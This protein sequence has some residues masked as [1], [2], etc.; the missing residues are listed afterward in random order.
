MA[1]LKK[2]LESGAVLEISM[3]SF[4]VGCRLLKAVTKEIESIK[5]SLGVGVTDIKYIFNEEINDSIVNTIKNLIART[6]SS[7][8]IEAM[9]WECM[10]R[11]TYNNQKITKETFESEQTRA[12]YLVVFNEVLWYNISPFLKNLG[13]VLSGIQ[14]RSLSN[15]K[16]K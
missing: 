2:T 7:D 6:I 5:I 16:Q 12:D 13:S 11:A 10:G 9:V 15:L 8:S 4:E 3:S 1:N 14:E